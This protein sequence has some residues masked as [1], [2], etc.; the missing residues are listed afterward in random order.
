MARIRSAV[1]ATWGREWLSSQHMLLV[2]Q[3]TNTCCQKMAG[4]PLLQHSTSCAMV[5]EATKWCLSPNR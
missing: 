5:L 4:L 1:E 2:I 3:L